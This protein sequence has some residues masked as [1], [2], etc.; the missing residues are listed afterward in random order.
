MNDTAT[1][2]CN[3]ETPD[4]VIIFSVVEHARFG[5]VSREGAMSALEEEI[6]LLLWMLQGELSP[7]ERQEAYRRLEQLLSRRYGGGP[8]MN[9]K[10]KGISGV[11]VKHGGAVKRVKG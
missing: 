3:T 6:G 4:Q 7:E 2:R 11:C 1:K 5:V 8:G 9:R 10:P